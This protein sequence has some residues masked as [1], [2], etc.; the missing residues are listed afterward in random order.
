MSMYCRVSTVLLPAGPRYALGAPPPMRCGSNSRQL[1][2]APN[3]RLVVRVLLL[4][5][6][7][8]PWP[9]PPELSWD[10]LVRMLAKEDFIKRVLALKPLLLQYKFRR[11]R[12]KNI[13][14]RCRTV[15]SV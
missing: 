7:G 1:M 5:A 13:N 2:A 14:E 12:K 9:T 10:A 8:N 3:P 6:E 15:K 4:I 11:G